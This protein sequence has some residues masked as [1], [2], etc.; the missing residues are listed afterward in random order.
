MVNTA[1]WCSCVILYKSPLS[2]WKK[3]MFWLLY[4]SPF[5]SLVI[6]YAAAA[7]WFLF[8]YYSCFAL[9]TIVIFFG[10]RGSGIIFH[11]F[12]CYLFICY[13]FGLCSF[14]I[15][16][17]VVCLFAVI[18]GSVL[19]GC[20]VFSLGVMLPFFRSSSS[21]SLSSARHFPFQQAHIN[22]TLCNRMP[23]YHFR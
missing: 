22:P 17:F 2:F 9:F 13:N 20:F 4:F 23:Q 15:S 18:S 11:I 10:W 6:E 16:L 5:I 3:S 12:V 21:L 19:C 14:S 8:L 7:L 1:M